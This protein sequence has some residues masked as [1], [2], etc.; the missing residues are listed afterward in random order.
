MAYL[1]PDQDGVKERIEQ[2]SGRKVYSPVEL[3]TD[4]SNYMNVYRGQVLLLNGR[5]FYILGD[6]AEPRFGMQDQPKY[7]VK[8]VVDLETGHVRLIKLVFHEEFTAHIGPIRIPCFRSP[9]KEARVL[10]LAKGDDRYM[11][12]VSALDERGNVVRI[13][14]WVYGKTLYETIMGLDM[15]HETYF[16]TVFPDILRRLVDVTLPAIQNLHN[17]S[18]CHGDI[19]NDHIIIEEGTGLYR[20]IDFD[21]TQRFSDYDEWSIG[22]VLQF[23][24]GKGM[25]TFH[26]VVESEKFPDRVA[27]KLDENDGSAFLKYRIMNLKKLYPYVPQRLN[28]VLMHFAKGTH[29]YYDRVDQMISELQEVLSVDFPNG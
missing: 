25:V 15:S 21:L 16:H 8:R 14:D 12:G 19:R 27:A 7:W 29:L 28:D 2:L 5:E 22:N 24:T 13:I 4:T 6:V 17:Y 10:D 1:H 20:W 23:C 11:Q 26:Q 3:V 18:L 9:E